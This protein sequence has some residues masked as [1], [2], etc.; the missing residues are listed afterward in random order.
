VDG[1]RAKEYEENLEVNLRGL[2]ERFKAGTYKAPPVRRSTSLR[3]MGKGLGRIGIPTFEDKV[4]Q[5]VVTMG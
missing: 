4:L 2:L 1:Q 3:G 5:R